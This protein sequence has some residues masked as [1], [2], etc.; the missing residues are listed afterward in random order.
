MSYL[1]ILE[2]RF[3]KYTIPNLTL[4]LIVGQVIAYAS[5]YLNP[6][7]SGLFVLQGKLLLVGEWWRIFTFIFAPF[8][9]NLFFVAFVWY[10]FYLYGTVLEHRWGDFRY[11][12]YLLISYIGTVLLAFLFPDASFSNGYLYTSLFLAFAYMYP[13]FQLLL[14]FILPVKVKWL[15]VLAWIGIIGSLIIGDLSAKILT[16]V[17][18]SNFFIFF[19]TDLLYMLRMG[20][21][22]GVKGAPVLRGIEKPMHVCAV[23]GKNEID[24]PAM[25]IRYCNDCIPDTC[26][27][28]EHINNHEHLKKT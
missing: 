11:F 23:C 18:I 10:I 4:Y 8:S 13:D 20:V 27:C 3:G 1:D 2:K 17:S 26:Y 22:K 28:G 14:F 12:I 19:G 7:Y 25:E 24:N 5:V 21:K 15:A 16:L 6:R 9:E